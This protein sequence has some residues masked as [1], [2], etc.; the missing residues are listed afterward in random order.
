MATTWKAPPHGWFKANWDIG[1]DSKRGQVGLGAVIHDQHGK[2]WV[3]KSQTQQGFLDPSAAEAMAALMAVQ[4]CMEMG[5]QQ[6]Q[7]EGDAKNVIVAVN[8]KEPDKSGR[9]QL[10]EDIRSTLQV[11]PVW[12]MRNAHREENKVAHALSWFGYL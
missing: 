9:G 6:V 7:L 11:I 2:M 3:S 12:E 10:T 1:V 8:S 5:I 4:L